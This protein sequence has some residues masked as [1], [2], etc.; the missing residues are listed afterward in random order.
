MKT[1]DLSNELLAKLVSWAVFESMR[2]KE[3]VDLA[4][5]QR[6]S[7]DQNERLRT[8]RGSGQLPV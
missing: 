8:N 7:R 5:A 4:F 1:K 6:A 3:F 2:P